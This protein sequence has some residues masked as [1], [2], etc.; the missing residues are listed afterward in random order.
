MIGATTDDVASTI[1][2][3]D[4]FLREYSVSIING[5]NIDVEHG[6]VVYVDENWVFVG[7]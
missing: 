3:L 4:I 7:A 5:Y 2:R 1:A 6:K